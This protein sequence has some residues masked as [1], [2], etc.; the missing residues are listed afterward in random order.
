MTDQS[1]PDPV[2]HVLILG[3]TGEARALA[4]TLA[5]TDIAF[6]SSLAGRVKHPRLPVGPVRIGGFGGSDGLREWLQSNRIQAVVDATHPFA[7]TITRNA[8]RATA[9]AGVPLL[10]LRRDPWVP[11]DTDT[12]IRVPDL[13]AAA[14]EVAARGRRVFLTTGRQDVG[15]FAGIDSAWFLIRVV[16]APTGALPPHHEVLRSRGPY[17]HR[18]ER[19]LL[20]DNDIDLLVTKNSGG[21]LTSAKLAAAAE[22]G[23]AVIMVDRPAEPDTPVVSD[24]GAARN[25][26]E[27]LS[28]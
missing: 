15:V 10:R 17:D 18:S 3:G 11:G 5:D 13:P 1:P 20:R 28:G 19:E 4:S 14:R 22:L 27:E 8:A 25:W 7:A 26:L 24:V 16:D 2:P 6:I 9:D 23:I 21:T 12:W